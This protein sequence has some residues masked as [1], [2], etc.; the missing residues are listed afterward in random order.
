[1]VQRRKSDV[2][3]RGEIDAVVPLDDMSF[4]LATNIIYYMR[5]ESME[6]DDRFVNYLKLIMC[7]AG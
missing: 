2:I 7:E 3:M 5:E 1:M 4:G 6:K